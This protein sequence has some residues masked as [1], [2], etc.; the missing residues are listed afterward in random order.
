MDL[1]SVLPDSPMLNG[2]T[3][4]FG[5]FDACS[6][7]SLHG[8]CSQL[9]YPLAK[10]VLMQREIARCLRNRNTSMP[11]QLYR[12]NPG[13][14]ETGSRPVLVIV[15]GCRK[16]LRFDLPGGQWTS[17]TGLAD[18]D[19]GQRRNQL[20]RV[21]TGDL[22]QFVRT[23]DSA[24]DNGLRRFLFGAVPDIRAEQDP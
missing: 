13:A 16:G 15:V 3:F 12:L 24:C 10:H 14:F 2:R 20:E 7:G 18:L 19:S 17:S 21:A 1:V 5:G 23:E 4:S 6:Q 8:I 11:D 9:P 22:L